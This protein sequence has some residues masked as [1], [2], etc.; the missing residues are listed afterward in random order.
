MYL[1]SSLK[2][3]IS[4][5]PLGISFSALA[6]RTEYSKVSIDNVSTK[7]TLILVLTDIIKMLHPFMPYVTDEIYDSLPVKEAVKRI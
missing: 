3:F 7:S 4:P 5:N 1:N 6:L 2:S